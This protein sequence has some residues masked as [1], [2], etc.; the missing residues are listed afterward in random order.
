MSKSH[1]NKVT[2]MFLKILW[3]KKAFSQAYF[4]L[5]IICL[6]KHYIISNR[7]WS[8]NPLVN[9]QTL[10]WMEVVGWVFGG[11]CPQEFCLRFL[12][13]ISSKHLVNKFNF[14]FTNLSTFYCS[15]SSP[16]NEVQGDQYLTF[17]LHVLVFYCVCLL[18]KIW[19]NL[20]NTTKLI[21]LD[22]L[23]PEVTAGANIRVVFSV[24]GLLA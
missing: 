22:S 19:R 3:K 20:S 1:W 18:N 10:V 11:L 7:A 2:L 14:L 16:R 21:L 12:T 17:S 9:F 5:K 6:V 23:L 13:I 15:I 4:F 8:H 24:H